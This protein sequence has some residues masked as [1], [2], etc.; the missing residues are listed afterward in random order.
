ME[1]GAGS[2]S[3]VGNAIGAMVK[4]GSWV[5]LDR[6]F[7]L[8]IAIAAEVLREVGSVSAGRRQVARRI[9]YIEAVALVKGRWQGLQ[10]LCAYL[11][12]K[13]SAKRGVDAQ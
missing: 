9:E 12:I 11:N 5:A 3:N 8:A 6:D 13:S 7:L 1:G 4:A 2:S 10:Q